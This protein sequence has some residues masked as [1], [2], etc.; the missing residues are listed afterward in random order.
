MTGPD[1]DDLVGV[2]LTPEDRA[3]L[4]RAHEALVAAGPPA[5]VP[6]HLTRPS[7]RVV[8][9]PRR[10][11]LAVGL[12]A[13]LTAGA[14]G[15]GYLARGEDGLET[16]FAVDMERTAAASARAGGELVVFR[17]DEAGNWPMAMT[18]WGL[19]E[20]VY[21]LLLTRDGKP[22][23][24]CGTF[25]VRKRTVAHL[26]APYKLK[27]Y[28]GWVVTRAGSEQALLRTPST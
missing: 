24:S 23:A 3:R 18:V 10:R 12:A 14:F 8:R 13:A 9:F 15:G 1:F 2:D 5:E 28:D 11:V 16:D 4:R 20:G 25:L 19:P 21:E 22:V 27:S 17:Q 6:A 26:T 7:G